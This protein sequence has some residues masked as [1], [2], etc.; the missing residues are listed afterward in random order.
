MAQRLSDKVAQDAEAPSAGHKIFYDG[1]PKAVKGFGLRITRAGA[2]SWVLN[3]RSG[4]VERRLTIGSW[5]DWKAGPAREEAARLKRLV[6]QGAD[7]MRDRHAE[8]VAPT[9]ADLGVRYLAEYAPKKRTGAQDEVT[10]RQIIVPALGN[11]KVADL[12]FEDCDR[13]HRSV[14]A[15]RGAVRANRALAL[16]STL[17]TL[18]MKWRMRPDSPTK[19]VEKNREERRARYLTGDELGRLMAVLAKRPERSADAV[20]LLLLTGARRGEVLKATWDQFDLSG[21]VWTKPSA[22]TKQ[23]KDQRVPLSGPA[24]QL[25]AAMWEQE[26]APAAD[27]EPHRHLFPSRGGD[28]AAQGDLKR[29]WQSVRREAGIEDVHIH[30]LRHT[31]ASALAGQGMSLPIIGALLGHTQAATTQRYA[32]LADAALRQ[33]TE[34][35][36]QAIINAGA[37]GGAEVHKLQPGRRRKS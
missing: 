25:L 15:D 9:V 37:P 8:R 21:G 2:R 18:A 23:K 33:A 7:P 13:L 22:H 10:L 35:A 29:F 1:G 31:Y 16:L 28:Q 30:D 6:D 27:R 14:T 36:G 11:R 4:G 19:G 17:M 5:P 20:R 26:K 32:H 24:R 3:Y 12:Q 34:R